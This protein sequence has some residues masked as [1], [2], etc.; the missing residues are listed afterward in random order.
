MFLQLETKKRHNYQLL[1][2]FICGLGTSL[3]RNE[4]R[5]DDHRGAVEEAVFDRRCRRGD[6]RNISPRDRLDRVVVASPAH[7]GVAVMKP[8]AQS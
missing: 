7:D 6:P 3:A 2:L 4:T 1:M 5:M 8:R